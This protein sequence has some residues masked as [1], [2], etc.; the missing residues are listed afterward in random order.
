[1]SLFLAPASMRGPSISVVTALAGILAIAALGQMLILMIGGIDLS[2]PVMV[3]VSAGIVIRYGLPGVDLL[4]VVLIALGVAVAFSLV[5]GFFI[6]VLRLNAL[7]V[8]LGTLGIGTGAITLWTGVSFS[9]TGAAPQALTSFARASVFNVNVCFFVALGVAAVL[10]VALA[11]TRVGRRVPAVGA[12]RRAARTLGTRTVAI[13]LGVFAGA[14]LL[15]GIAGVLIAGFIGTPDTSIGAPYQL[16]TVTAAAIAGVALNGG[17][18]SVAPVIGASLF[19]QLLDQ[20][21]AIAGL[22]T[23]VGTILQGISLVVAV[24]AITIW[25]LLSTGVRRV[26]RATRPRS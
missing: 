23:G 5:N 14:G 20:V 7:I 9:L 3:A 25:Q 1:M 8:T 2:V 12:N 13:E 4:P 21:I 15:Y 10:G 6:S 22:P 11:R 19:L 24:A 26:G 17:P 16:A 18:G